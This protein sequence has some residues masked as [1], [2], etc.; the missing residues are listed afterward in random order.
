MK[1]S[2][3]EFYKGLREAALKDTNE[4]SESVKKK[5][6]AHKYQNNEHN[7]TDI[8]EEQ[9]EN[10][11]ANYIYTILSNA[12]QVIPY[13][14]KKEDLFKYGILNEDMKKI[15]IPKND[16]DTFTKKWKELQKDK[17]DELTR[18]PED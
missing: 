8:K 7:N 13:G 14:L 11:L 15:I 5:I 1:R 4:R 18:S 3:N 9:E 17:L 2:N 12:G 16:I 10:N 6:A